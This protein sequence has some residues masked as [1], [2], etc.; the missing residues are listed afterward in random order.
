MQLGT[1]SISPAPPPL[2]PFPPP[3]KVHVRVGAVPPRLFAYWS[4]PEIPE[5][6]A[7]CFAAMRQTNPAWNF[8]ILSSDNFDA[9]GLAP[10]PQPP[11]GTVDTSHEQHMADWYRVEVIA[12]Y[13]GV[14]MDATNVNFLPLEN[15]VNVSSPAVQGFG[16]PAN[17]VQLGAD[18]ALREEMENWAFAA[19]LGSAFVARW[20]HHFAEALSEGTDA[21]AARQDPA[22]TGALSGYL[23]EHIGWVLT[24][25]E[26]SRDAA[27]TT[28]LSSTD[29]GR[30][31]HFMLE[32]DWV[33]CWVA[34]YTMQAPRSKFGQETA[35]LK[36]RG[37]ERG[38]VSPLWMYSYFRFWPFADASEPSVAQWLSAQLDAEPDLK[39]RSFTNTEVV[40]VGMFLLQWWIPLLLITLG[41]VAL[42]YAGLYCFGCACCRRCTDRHAER[43]RKGRCCTPHSEAETVGLTDKAAPLTGS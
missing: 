24:R 17:T 34:F 33:S 26:L 7:A 16:R 32:Y 14:Y 39:A 10:P 18:G 12:K 20:R 37:A 42:C 30:P 43:C 31:F 13:G 1:V 23:A 41:A 25:Q 40:H 4:S 5:F 19:P 36:F 11:V 6:A 3:S 22:V 28:V 29:V 27:P 2:P 8:T 15:W 21:W 35:F 38:C 9:L